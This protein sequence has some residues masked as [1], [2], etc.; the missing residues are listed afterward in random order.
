MPPVVG[1]PGL[2]CR[3]PGAGARTRAWAGELGRTRKRGAASGCVRRRGQLPGACG[4]AVGRV[5]GRWIRG[6]W[7][8]GGCRW[9]RR[10]GFPGV[11]VLVVRGGAGAVPGVGLVGGG[12]PV[13]GVEAFLVGG[14]AFLAAAF[15][16][17]PA[18]GHDA[19]G[20]HREDQQHHQLAD[21][22]APEQAVSGELRP[23]RLRPGGGEVLRGGDQFAQGERGAGERDAVRPA[24]VGE[25]AGQ[26]GGRPG[27]ERGG[28]EEAEEADEQA[29]RDASAAPAPVVSVAGGRAPAP[30]RVTCRHV[31]RPWTRTT[32]SSVVG[33]RC[34]P[35]AA[36]PPVR[37]RGGRRGAG[38]P[39]SPRS[40]RG[41]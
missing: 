7:V 17:R 34:G 4:C 18:S 22:Q 15:P 40:W 11:G 33:A 3:G 39:S 16:Y 41:R 1:A 26:A 12:G 24:P 2:R 23:G 35:P 9:G 32:R 37:R 6:R 31:R 30:Y 21:E 28:E 38:G 25:E 20:E 5:R 36:P 29:V 27:D 14:G 19:D 13:L 8:R 10:G